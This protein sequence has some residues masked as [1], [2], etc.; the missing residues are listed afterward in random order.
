MRAILA[1]GALV[2]AFICLVFIVV[3]D[4]WAMT[5]V[6]T[7]LLCT[8]VLSFVLSMLGGV[9]IVYR[10]ALAPKAHDIGEHGTVFE[11]LGRR[12]VIYPERVIEPSDVKVI[13]APSVKQLPIMSEAVQLMGDRFMYGYNDALEPEYGEWDNLNIIIVLGMS[14]SGKSNT[15]L[16]IAI[17]ALLLGMEVTVCDGNSTKSRSISAMISPLRG[18]VKIATSDDD[19]HGAVADYIME[20]NRRKNGEVR[21]FKP[22]VLIF[23][24]WTEKADEFA[25]DIET[26]IRQGS[27]YNMYVVISGQL[28]QQSRI[29]STALRNSI[30]SAF[31]HRIP[32]QE[33]KKILPLPKHH[34]LTDQLP[35]GY[36]LM[37]DKQGRVSRL[38]VPHG[39]RSSA[40]EVKRMFEATYAQG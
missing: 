28:A 37:K 4:W 30:Q 38:Y 6:A 17:Q 13:D 31:V 3:V 32:A 15:L 25:D 1:I 29:G 27:G 5:V 19:I 40:V 22:T 36:M 24:E 33:S 18:K 35:T 14:Q 9:I 12:T 16:F 34:T 11:F 39:D 8:I 26:L 23:D 2:I 20:L 21:D 10:F 7:I